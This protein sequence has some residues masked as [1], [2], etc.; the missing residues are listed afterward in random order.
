MRVD[1]S[2]I[3]PTSEDLPER[4]IAFHKALKSWFGKKA[5]NAYFVKFWS[6]RAGEGSSADTHGLREYM[7]DQG[8]DLTTNWKGEIADKTL[9]ALDW[10]SDTVNI[11]RAII[12]G[13]IIV[14]VGVGAY[15]VIKKAKNPNSSNG[16][17]DASTLK[18]NSGVKP[19]ILPPNAPIKYL[20]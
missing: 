6:Q 10:V 13:V 17:K 16:I 20:P 5:A 3:I 12:I 4:W 1:P 18:L 19:M 8:V 11:L 14:A 9:G 7:D 15:Y 2:K